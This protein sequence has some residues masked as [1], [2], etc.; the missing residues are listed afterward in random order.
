LKKG[1]QPCPKNESTA[2]FLTKN[3]QKRH[4][5]ALY[6]KFSEVKVVYKTPRK[7]YI[8]FSNF[9]SFKEF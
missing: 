7:D 6:D 9:L 1:T 4:K 3:R 5:K 8:F 2:G